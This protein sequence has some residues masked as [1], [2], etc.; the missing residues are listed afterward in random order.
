MMRKI[1]QLR[2]ARRYKDTPYSYQFCAQR[3]DAMVNELAQMTEF[4]RRF[5]DADDRDDFSDIIDH[6]E[7]LTQVFNEKARLAAFEESRLTTGRFEFDPEPEAQA[8][9]A[10]AEPVRKPR[11]KR[12]SRAAASKDTS[13]NEVITQFADA[14]GSSAY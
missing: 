13:S 5:G 14:N 6:L 3:F 2:R 4:V 9:Q 12:G 1:N 7:T 10:V 8:E 11:T